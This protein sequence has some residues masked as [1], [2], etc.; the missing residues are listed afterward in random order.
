MT[1]PTYRTADVD[2]FEV[3]YREAGDRSKPTLLLHGFPTSS[4][5]RGTLEQMPKPGRRLLI[6]TIRRLVDGTMAPML[7]ATTPNTSSAT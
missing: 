7:H 3:F 6:Q 5:M 2:G 1:H 4:H